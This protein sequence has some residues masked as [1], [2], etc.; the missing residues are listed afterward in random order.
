M[1]KSYSELIKIFSFEDRYEYLK[2]SG[3]VGRETFGYDR[4]LNQIFYQSKEWRRVR[5]QVIIRDNG[6][7]L[8]IKGREISGRIYVHHINPI[9]VEDV[10]YNLD[11]CLDPNNLICSSFN[12]HQAIH[13]SDKGLLILNPI[14]R[15]LNDT[16]PWRC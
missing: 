5:D 3:K 14:E 8:G 13:Y 4:Y 12:T 6:Y 15:K 2:L 1:N 9:T 10:L 16:I 7:D 11:Y